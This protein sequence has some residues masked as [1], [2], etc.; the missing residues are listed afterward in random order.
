M[1]GIIA[2]GGDDLS[3]LARPQARH[4]YEQI[5]PPRQCTQF[6][7]LAQLTLEKDEDFL[8]P[9][10]AIL[11]GRTRKML[12]RQDPAAAGFSQ[13]RRA[14]PDRVDFSFDSPPSAYTMM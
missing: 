10:L 1:S 7:E 4:G 14:A 3:L 2:H 13:R 5:I 8:L 6:I 9:A 12:A 11:A